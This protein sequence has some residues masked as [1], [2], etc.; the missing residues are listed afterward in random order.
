MLKERAAFLGRA[1]VGLHMLGGT[2]AR[3]RGRSRDL[4]AVAIPLLCAPISTRCDLEFHKD[5]RHVLLFTSRIV[6]FDPMSTKC[7]SVR[8]HVSIEN[9]QA[10]YVSFYAIDIASTASTN[11]STRRTLAL[12]PALAIALLCVLQLS[13]SK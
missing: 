2:C 9:T 7:R 6:P 11:A 3:T 5:H 1:P 10:V 4:T 8:R 12:L 13:N